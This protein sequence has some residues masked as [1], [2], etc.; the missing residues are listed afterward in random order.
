MPDAP[1]ITSIETVK[2]AALAKV[3]GP[4][5]H[6]P[7][8]NLRPEDLEVP[9]LKL[10]QA[11]SKEAQEGA[12]KPGTIINTLTMDAVDQPLT[13]VPVLRF[14]GRFFYRPKQ[15]DKMN[16]WM[17]LCTGK[18]MAKSFME[19]AG[20]KMD[21]LCR[22]DDCRTGTRFGACDACPFSQGFPSPCTSLMNFIVVEPTKGHAPRGLSFYKTSYKAGK[23]INALHDEIVGRDKPLYLRSYKMS[24][25]QTTN[26]LGTFYVW[27]VV[28]GEATTPAV[29]AQAEEVL[30]Q[31][32]E[33]RRVLIAGMEDEG[34]GEQD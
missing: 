18:D 23:R 20:T 15:Q 10:I 22:S 5:V 28:P 7:G 34:G 27:N 25:K 11:M 1:R 9:R 26:D 31:A 12:A 14:Y 19:A 32:M 24:A 17:D 4:F 29:V 33:A 21:I 6:T 30:K 16:A 2:P 8:G 3:A 13:I